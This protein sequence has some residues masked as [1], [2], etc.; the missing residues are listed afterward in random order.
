MSDQRFE[1][2]VRDWL[3]AGSDRTP[4][5]AIDA[6]LLAAKTTPQER[7][8]WIPRRF[9]A[10]TVPMRFAAGAA[11]VAVLGFAALTLLND[12]PGVGGRATP[13][14]TAPPGAAASP[15]PTATLLDTAPWTRFRSARY[16][17]SVA[18]PEGWTA[19]PA[20]RDFVLES[21]RLNPDEFVSD[22]FID[23]RVTDSAQILLSAFAAT[24]PE[25]MSATTW[26]DAYQA[27][28]AGDTSGCKQLSAQMTPIDVD[29]HSG[30]LATNCR[31][32]EAFVLVGNRMYAFTVWR[33]GQGALLDAFLAT[34]QL[35]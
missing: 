34:V 27:P 19:V 16:G 30:L 7:V 32:S 33:P 8:L 11:I 13:V 10:M 28:E 21:D 23:R 29:G 20:S 26:I 31:W 22:D 2:A 14:P 1:S 35:P 18:Y 4:R 9:N 25:G 24:V 5:P 12:N 15:T 17:F 3:E 6:V